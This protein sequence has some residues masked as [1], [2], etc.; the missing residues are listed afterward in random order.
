MTYKSPL[1]Q[2]IVIAFVLLTVVVSGLF[3]FGMNFAVDSLERQLMMSDLQQ[4]FAITRD[5]YI[6]HRNHTLEAGTKF[7]VGEQN[8]PEGFRSLPSG[9]N[10][11]SLKEGNF[12][13]YLSREAGM[14]YC[15]V[16]DRTDF[17]RHEQAINS[18]LIYGF[19]LSVL[20][21]LVLGLILVRRIIAPLRRLTAQVQSRECLA[22]D[23]S[24]LAGGYPDDE[25]GHLA[26]TFDRTVL[27]LQQALQREAQFTNDVSHELR[28]ALMTIKSSCDLLVEK[29]QL[30]DYSRGKIAVIDNATEE[31]QELVGAFLTLAREKPTEEGS[32]SLME[33]VRTGEQAWVEQA[34]A[35]DLI[36]SVEDQSGETSGQIKVYPKSLLRTVL[37]NL[38]RNAIYHS[39]QGKIRLTVTAAGFILCDSGPGVAEKDKKAIFK[40]FFRGTTADQN[41]IGL[42]LSLVQRICQREGWQIEIFDNHPTGC[43]FQVL[44]S[45]LGS[46]RAT[47][48]A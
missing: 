19:W 13:V 47:S 38:V 11:I 43:C 45:P 28:T 24:P 27:R 10:E 23:A 1:S 16:K 22:V 25:I 36:L 12:H 32:A 44:L 31:L 40:P 6:Y 5:D 48:P 34:R 42:G 14:T 35:R 30:D 33:L 20:S 2:R 37:N 26:A 8:L 41:G 15:L 7:F 4:E 21:A 17:E 9:W 18:D 39:R 29:D 3:A 46:D